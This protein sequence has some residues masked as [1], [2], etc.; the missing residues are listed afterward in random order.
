MDYII[1]NGIK[2]TFVK[3][4]LI[5]ELAPITKPLIRSQIEEI[6]GR[7]GDIVTKLGYA[8][9]DKEVLIGLHSGFDIDEVIK[10]FNGEGEVTFSNEPDK[11]YKYQILAQIDFE[12][13]IRF[14]QA[15]VTFHVQP[16]K[17][18]AVEKLLLENTDNAIDIPSFTQTQD[19]VTVSVSNDTITVS[20]TAT[21]SAEFFIP[22]SGSG[23]ANKCSLRVIGSAPRDNDSLCGSYM[24]VTDGSLRGFLAANHTYNYIWLMVQETYT[25]TYN[26]TVKVD[27]ASIY[28]TNQGNIVAKPVIELQGDGVV[29]LFINSIKKLTVDLSVYHNMVIDADAM[30]A[31]YGD[32]LLNRYVIGDYDEV[33]LPVGKNRISWTGTISRIQVDHYSRWV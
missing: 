23:E 26:M 22:I 2:S 13:L 27:D 11:V 16:F 25:G 30:D 17:H 19:G 8:A 32:K 33:A 9:Y 4:L 31:Y 3:G 7:D 20:G 15:T 18:S 21:A 28:A 10:Y 12:K 14:R 1:L 24:V 29:E 6:N 5:Q